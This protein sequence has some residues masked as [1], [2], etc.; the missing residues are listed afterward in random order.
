LFKKQEI[1]PIIRVSRKVFFYILF[2]LKKNIVKL[3]MPMPR[4]GEC[5]YFGGNGLSASYIEI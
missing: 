3:S 1:S 2:N 4:S 5:H